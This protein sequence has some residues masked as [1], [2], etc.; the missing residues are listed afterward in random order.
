MI[1]V[2]YKIWSLFLEYIGTRL[3]AIMLKGRK[4]WDEISPY[5]S[6]VCDIVFPSDTVLYL[7]VYQKVQ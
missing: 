5:V 2:F 3:A 1:K 4:D 6:L 7:F